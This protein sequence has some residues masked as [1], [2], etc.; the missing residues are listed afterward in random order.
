MSAQR[1]WLVS[2]GSVC[3]YPGGATNNQNNHSIFNKI[4]DYVLNSVFT[5]RAYSISKKSV[6]E[7]A[8]MNPSNTNWIQKLFLFDLIATEE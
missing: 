1:A 3:F 5:K 8:I 6:Q 4:V 7:M 2:N